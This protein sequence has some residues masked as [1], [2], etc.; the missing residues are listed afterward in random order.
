MTTSCLRRMLTGTIA[1][2]GLSLIAP[3]APA[4][5]QDYTEFG[6]LICQ[7]VPRS[8]VNLIIRSTQDVRCT[9]ETENGEEA[10]RGETGI[11]FGID[12]TLGDDETLTWLVFMADIEDIPEYALA[13]RYIGAS[14][15]VAVGLGA[16]VDV[17]ANTENDGIVLQPVAVRGGT[18]VGAAL[19]IG[20]LY[21][22][23]DV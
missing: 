11:E 4:V 16:G 23:P 20:Y 3:A 17:L 22:E 2:A 18:G 10:Y 5:A 6:T 15:T 19:G 8:G 14:A 21:L 7:S 9:F 13:G 1:A 12:L